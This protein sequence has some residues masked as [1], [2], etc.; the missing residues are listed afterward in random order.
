MMYSWSQAAWIIKYIACEQA[1]QEERKLPWK[2]LACRLSS[3]LKGKFQG[4]V[5]R[6]PWK[7]F[8]PFLVNLYLKT[9]KWII[10]LETSCMEETSVIIRFVRFCY[11][12]LGAK[13]FSGLS[14][15]R[16]LNFTPLHIPVLGTVY[17]VNLIHILHFVFQSLLVFAD[18][19]CFP[20][21]FQFLSLLF[22][23]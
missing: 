7:R 23:V 13:N 22:L 11:S 5:S 12:F 8:R 10:M 18:S 20:Y 9:E 1:L 17:L 3:M 19:I 15:N 16:P 14:Q 6:K 21:F 2:E 4:P